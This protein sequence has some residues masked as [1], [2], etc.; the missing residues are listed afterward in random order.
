MNKIPN[1]K[2]LDLPSVSIN[3]T[4]EQFRNVRLHFVLGNNQLDGINS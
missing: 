1:E 4:R 3:I 2:W